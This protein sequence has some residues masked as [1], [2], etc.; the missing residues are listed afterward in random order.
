MRK[1][2]QTLGALVLFSGLAVC[3]E[4]QLMHCFAYTPIETAT[5]AEWEAFY[6][7]TD[8][9]PK[10]I[11]QIKSVWYGKL[12]RPLNQYATTD[13]EARKKAIAGDK[14]ATGP[15][16]YFKREHGVCMAFAS[17]DPALLKEYTSNP[18]HKE[19]TAAYEKVRVAGTTT[20][21]IIGQ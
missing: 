3:G 8:Q 5:P 11:K 15:I 18:Y 13:A 1:L 14:T 21:D 2:G 12:A 20:F 16:A 10:K 6:K 19:W 4:K 17:A 7:A 9:L